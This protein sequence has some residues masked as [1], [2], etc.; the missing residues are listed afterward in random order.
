MMTSRLYITDS[1]DLFR[2]EGTRAKNAQV[3]FFAQF[4]F[5]IDAFDVARDDGPVSA[6]KQRHLVLGE[7]YRILVGI[8]AD[9]E[10]KPLVRKGD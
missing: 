10:G 9:I 7:P 6:K 2:V 3:L 4:V 8:D 5:P 1:Y